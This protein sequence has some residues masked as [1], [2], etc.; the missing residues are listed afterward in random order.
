MAAHD[1]F[2]HLHDEDDA[3]PYRAGMVGAGSDIPVNGREVVSL[4]G[5]WRMTL[6]LFDEGQRQKWFAL[7]EVPPSQWSEPRDDEIDA[8][9][10][11]PV[12]SCWNVLKPEWTWFEGAA[13]YTRHVDWTKGPPDEEVIPR[14]H[15]LR[16]LRRDCYGSHEP[17]LELLSSHRTHPAA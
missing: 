12:P 5:D 7:D 3:R 16:P 11:V 15:P 8:G 17:V 6:D 1:P 9:E 4:N 10:L 13:W 2:H 14:S